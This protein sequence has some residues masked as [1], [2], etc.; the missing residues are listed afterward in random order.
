MGA[1][2]LS[3][4]STGDESLSA[5]STQ[6]VSLGY[7]SR[8]LDLR[9]LFLAPALPP[10][11]SA[12]ALKRHHDLLVLQA[13]ARD[14]IAKCLWGM[15]E[16]RQSERGVM[17]GLL[18]GEARASE[19]ADRE[20]KGRERA[21]RDREAMGR[22][23]EAERARV[24]ELEAK[25]KAEQER[26]RHARE[27]LG[28]TKNALQFVKTQASHD[29]KRRESEVQALHQ[30]LQKLTTA[31]SSSSSSDT[32]FTRFIVLN[33]SSAS[34]PVSSPLNATFG[35]AGGRTSRLGGRT[36]TP[37]QAPAPVSAALEAELDLVR[38]ALDE[39]VAAR[40]GLEGENADLRAFVGEVGEWAEGMLDVPELVGVRKD[41]VEGAE[42][43]GVLEGE[44]DESYL[45][46]TPHLAL[47]VPAMTAPLHRKLYAIRLGLLSLTSS[48]SSE[49]SALR[50]E[51]EHEVERLHEEVEE[52]QRRREVVEGERDEAR[53]KVEA[54]EKVVREW[55]E[56]AARE[57]QK[58]KGDESEDDLPPE[59]ET[60]LAL[61]K[62]KRLARKVAKHCPSSSTS[63]PVPAP[64]AAASRPSIPSAHVSAFLSELGLDTPGLPS[65]SG[66]GEKA[67][68][69]ADRVGT[70]AITSARERELAAGRGERTRPS[71]APPP[72]A[73]REKDGGKEGAMLP[74]AAPVRRVSSSRAPR[75]DRE[76][77]GAPRP[78]RAQQAMSST[79][80][81]ILA[82]AA[83]PPVE[84]QPLISDRAQAQAVLG[85][86]RAA[87]GAPSAAGGTSEEAR[88]R[89]KKAALLAKARNG[90]AQITQRWEL[91]SDRP[92][93]PATQAASTMPDADGT[94]N[95]PSFKDQVNAYSKKF[96]G[97]VF[98]KEHE[99]VLGTSLQEGRGKDQALR[100]AEIV[101]ERGA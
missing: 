78:P 38:T 36:P 65:S 48:S 73:E 42:M 29:Q 64:S 77:D 88:V 33:A 69:K 83:S 34:P 70:A 22:E 6:L 82:L 26:H 49:L 80:Q 18:A 52:E 55:A 32:A 79:L 44:A 43:R 12:K 8:P 76:R 58:A 86:S 40:A 87:N 53:E 27:E 3:D 100:D 72:R 11:P 101:K 45:V 5:L 56:R 67:P 25:L 46:P 14:Q 20:R 59:I 95:K 71:L 96:A 60:S 91:P 2:S 16:Q 61:D 66:S 50:E 9:T 1:Q 21:E 51:L 99:V 68:L 93:I 7:L 54:G 97:K 94:S 39:C 30:R 90:R 57:A 24:K 98:G 23:L 74:P 37:P 15:L 75:G 85:A 17:E 92:E 63:A 84:A 4:I 31:P 47:P 10:D 28:K 19:D 62:Q 41:G 89:E 35:G 13:R 81:D